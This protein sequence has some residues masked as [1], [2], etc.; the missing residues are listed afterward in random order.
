MYGVKA[1]ERTGLNELIYAW[2]FP[3]WNLHCNVEDLV[4]ERSNGW[5]K[6]GERFSSMIIDLTG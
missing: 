2:I 6:K 1:K 3:T 5:I 4:V